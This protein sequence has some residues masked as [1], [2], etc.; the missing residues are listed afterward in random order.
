MM[1]EKNNPG[2]WRAMRSSDVGKNDKLTYVVAQFLPELRG[3]W[4]RRPGER[5][6]DGNDLIGIQLFLAGRSGIAA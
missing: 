2:P 3:S 1:R 6:A 4:S 5:S